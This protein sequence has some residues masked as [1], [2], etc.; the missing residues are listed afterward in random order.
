MNCLHLKCSAITENRPGQERYQLPPKHLVNYK[1]SLQSAALG[2]ST[3]G[4][5][6]GA[7]GKPQLITKV[8]KG[9]IKG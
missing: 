6:V 7:G 1:I 8:G 3:A 4:S 2:S 5:A 9:E